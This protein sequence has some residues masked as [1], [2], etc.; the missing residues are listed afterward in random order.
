MKHLGDITTYKVY[1]HRFPNGKVY[2]G[3][4][5]RTPQYR[6][7]CGY[8][9]NKLLTE[10]IREFGWKSVSVDILHETDNRGD[11]FTLEIEE[12]ENADATN[13]EHGY[14]VSK[15]GKSTFSGLHHTDEQRGK[16]S[17][18]NKG[19]VFTAEHIQNLRKGHSKERKPV[20]MISYDQSAKI[21]FECLGD[22]AK[23]LSCHKSN[24][25]RACKSGKPYKGYY[26]M[27]ESE[28]MI[29]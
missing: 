12:I 19:I 23:S 3:V 26:W 8:Q 1:R 15:G 5:S 16:I 29:G 21:K 27:F 10:A 24:I 28:V 13:P 2:I 22:A 6:K 17:A 25:S 11:A 20:V 4:T 18:A 7:D 9:H 14:N